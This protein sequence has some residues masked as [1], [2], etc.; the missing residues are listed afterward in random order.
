MPN[1]SRSSP[2]VCGVCVRLAAGRGRVRCG[3]SRSRNWRN[4]LYHL[5]GEASG[6]SRPT[7]R[8]H[9]PRLT[10]VQVAVCEYEPIKAFQSH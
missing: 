8:A 1:L 5:T 4:I 6:P 2:G 3:L 10:G 9:L 7:R